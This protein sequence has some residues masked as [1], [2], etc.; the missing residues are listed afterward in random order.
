TFFSKYG[1]VVEH[2]IVRDHGTNRSRGFGF[3]AFDSEEVVDELVSNGNMID[4]AGNQVEIKKAEPK[5]AS[6]PPF[7]SRS[8]SRSFPDKFSGYDG[9]YDSFDG[10]YGPGPNR[11]S[12]VP[13]IVDGYS[14]YNPY[15]APWG[16]GIT[17]GY[18]R[19]APYTVRRGPGIAD[20]YS[21]YTSYRAPGDNMS[22][23]PMSG[24][25]YGRYGGEA[26]MHGNSAE[27]PYDV[28]ETRGNGET[29][30]NAGETSPRKGETFLKLCLSW[31]TKLALLVGFFASPYNV[32]LA[33]WMT[34]DI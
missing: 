32:E 1:K 34:W 29:R 25:Y 9:A 6:N 20:G 13:G 31:F 5:K 10:R 28:S 26:R 27:M 7:V 2:Q 23:Y 18:S 21:R 3:V 30:G 15:R 17:R 8:G 16:P 14:G 12:G 19:Y 11:A 33:T 4:M 22:G 24:G